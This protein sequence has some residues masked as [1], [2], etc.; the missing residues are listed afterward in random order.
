MNIFT[1]ALFLDPK[2]DWIQLFLNKWI[3][4]TAHNFKNILHLL[5]DNFPD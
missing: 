3:T 1:L 4:D 2:Q 5:L